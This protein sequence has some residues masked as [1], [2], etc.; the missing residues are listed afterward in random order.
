MSVVQRS[1]VSLDEASRTLNVAALILDDDLS[2]ATEEP[3]SSSIT[4]TSTV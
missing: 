1:K 4:V 2:V 3:P